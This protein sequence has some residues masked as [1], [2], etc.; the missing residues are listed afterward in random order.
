MTAGTMGAAQETVHRHRLG[1]V[2]AALLAVTLIWGFNSVAVKIALKEFSP[3]CFNALRFVLA[4][5]LTMGLLRCAEGRIAPPGRDLA[6]LFGIGFLGNTVYQAGF[7]KGLALSTAGNVSFVLATMPATTALL[8]HV[9]RIEALPWRAWAGMGG[10]LAGA[11]L[12]IASGSGGSLSLGGATARGDLMV[13]GGTLGWCLYTIYSRRIISRYTPLRL[14]AWTMALG[15]V[16]LVALAWPELRAQDWSRP[17]ALHWGILAGSAALALVF[18][19]VVWNWGLSRIGTARTAIYGNI[20]PL[21]TGF[22]GWLLLGE[23]WPPVRVAGAA[24]ILGGVAV[25]R[26]TRHAVPSRPLAA[27]GHLPPIKAQGRTRGASGA[28]KLD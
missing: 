27:R 23:V 2:D 8:A 21:W 16:P 7:I 26:G 9:L 15:A 25:V 22:F 18:S 4:S 17:G 3:L 1:A 6:L 19:Y 24:L 11:V 13:L 20:S 14:T 10:T 5:T 28:G 12:I